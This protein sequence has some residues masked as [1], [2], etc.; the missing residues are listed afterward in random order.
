MSK[1]FKDSDTV[2]LLCR[3]TV[4]PSTQS[5]HSLSNEKCEPVQIQNNHCMKTNTQLCSV[6]TATNW[7]KEHGHHKAAIP[8][9]IRHSPG[10][11]SFAAVFQTDMVLCDGRALRSQTAELGHRPLCILTSEPLQCT[12]KDWT[13]TSIREWCN[14]CVPSLALISFKKNPNLQAP[15]WFCDVNWDCMNSA[16][17]KVHF[18]GTFLIQTKT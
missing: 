6:A 12:L 18:R 1:F 16:N 17:S 3:C 14:S 10:C 13:P 8:T 5:E 15:G 4:L 11:S 2:T 9:N 7:Q